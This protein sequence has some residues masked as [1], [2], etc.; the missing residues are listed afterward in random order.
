MS[1]TRILG[2]VACVLTATFALVCAARADGS[3]KHVGG[4]VD[5]GES[6]LA[7]LKR[8]AREEVG[9]LVDPDFAPIS[10]GGWQISRARDGVVNDNFRAYV[11]RASSEDFE[12]DANE[13][14]SARWFDTASLMEAWRDAGR[15]DPFASP[16]VHAPD[17]LVNS[18]DL[19]R[20]QRKLGSK[21][22]DWLHCYE[23]GRG[24]P[25]IVREMGA[26]QVVYTAGNRRGEESQ[27][28]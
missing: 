26:G 3:W 12:V 20:K 1:I 10:V 18:H 22:L 8:E 25:C 15:P 19:P 11:V 23:S 27:S 28:V 5:E 9:V 16:G 4:A 13:I 24:L 7:A 2:E 6:V 14:S 17:A 21:T